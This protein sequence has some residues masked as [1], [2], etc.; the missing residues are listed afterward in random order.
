[1]ARMGMDV[2]EVERVATGLHN[3]ANALGT[4]IT[5]INGLIHQAVQVWEGPDSKQFLD[6]W[7]SQHQPA[8][9]RAKEAIEGLS[10]SARNNAKAQREV[11]GH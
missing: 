9:N 3:Q 10:T 6:W 1:M 2:D 7:N 11:S 4:A 8:L 5:T